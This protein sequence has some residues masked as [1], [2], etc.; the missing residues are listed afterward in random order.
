MLLLF[1]MNLCSLPSQFSTS[2]LS[3]PRCS[4]CHQPDTEGTFTVLILWLLAEPACLNFNLLCWE[5]PQLN[6]LFC[7]EIGMF[8][9]VGCLRS[10]RAVSPFLLAAV[11]WALWVVTVL[12]FK[13]VLKA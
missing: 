5:R 3:C 10:S 11:L 9:A 2:L 12:P 7:W 8:A 13:T 6:W 4:K 1:S